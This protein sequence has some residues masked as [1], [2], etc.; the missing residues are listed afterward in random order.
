MTL[1]QAFDLFEKGQFGHAMTISAQLIQNGIVDAEDT[2][3]AKCLSYQTI[4]CH[5]LGKSDEAYRS[6]LLG[7][8]YTHYDEN[9]DKAFEFLKKEVVPFEPGPIVFGLGTGRSGSTSLASMLNS[10]EGN[11][12]T[13]EHPFLVRWAL[14][15]EEVDW[16]LRRMVWLSRY[17]ALVGD[18]AHWWLPYVEFIM[19]KCA[20][21][22]FIAVKRAKE[23]TVRS[24]VRHKLRSDGRFINHWTNHDGEIF[25]KNLW[26]R[27]YPKYESN[28][29]L[30]DALDLY[31]QEYYDECERLV[32]KYPN[33][34]AMIDLDNLSDS[35]ALETALQSLGVSTPTPLRNFKKNVGSNYDSLEPAQVPFRAL[36]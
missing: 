16:H 33:R 2:P 25:H 12:V 21:S 1:Q 7:M 30:N 9:L 27:C 14:G 34:V 36:G 4:V 23:S 8:R 5:L 35:R 29:P 22:V 17:Y 20:S 31:W 3:Y 28:M 26:D 15:E 19:D 18:V 10:P 32:S 13:H 24:F 11:Y 6:A